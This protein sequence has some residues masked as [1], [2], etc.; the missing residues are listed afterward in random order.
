MLARGLRLRSSRR[1]AAAFREG[2]RLSGDMVSLVWRARED[3]LPTQVAITAMRKVGRK[4]A[5]NRARRR[6]RAVVQA[7]AGGLRPGYD[8]ILIARPQALTAAFAVLAEEVRSL[9]ASAGVWSG[10]GERP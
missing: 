2:R 5:R 9:M 4:P 1:I 8:V 7:L 6:L 3:G 10:G